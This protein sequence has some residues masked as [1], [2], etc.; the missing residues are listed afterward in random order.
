MTDVVI[1]A[2]ATP[3]QEA[4]PLPVGT[5]LAV[6]EPI[7]LPARRAVFKPDENVVVDIWVTADDCV[8]VTPRMVADLICPGIPVNEALRF[9]LV[10]RQAGVNPFGKEIYIDKRA[11]DKGKM[12]YMFIIGQQALRRL[13]HQHPKFIG[14]TFEDFPKF[15]ESNPKYVTPIMGR[16]KVWREGAPEPYV[17]EV[18]FEEVGKGKKGYAQQQPREFLRGIAEARACRHAFP[19][20]FSGLYDEGERL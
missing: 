5:E 6:Q 15:D 1:D 14:M 10:C 3:V 11:N 12:E 13:A 20:K 9:L 2:E 7:P 8:R 16:A 4:Q 19:D 17:Q 18:Y